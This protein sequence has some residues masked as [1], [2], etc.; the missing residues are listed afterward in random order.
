MAALILKSAFAKLCGVT[1]AAITQAIARG[2]VVVGALNKIDPDQPINL[3]YRRNLETRRHRGPK[4][5]PAPQKPKPKAVIPFPVD[6]GQ[7]DQP[8]LQPADG[9]GHDIDA[10]IAYVNK[11]RDRKQEADIRR[12]N[13]S[14][15]KANTE[16]AAKMGRLVER[17]IVGQ[18]AGILGAELRTRLVEM[19]KRIAPQIVA[20]VKSGADVM[21]I[22]KDLEAEIADA[23]KH[24]KEA[25]K[26]A[27]LTEFAE[28]LDE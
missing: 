10:H 15:T 20:L 8:N 9:N 16:T 7:S 4:K 18:Y 19:P 2:V 17:K 27:T 6:S 22:V 5:A 21:E 14:A 28:A 3:E 26:I 12:I 25:A 13:A 11:I 24:A 1:P 23:I